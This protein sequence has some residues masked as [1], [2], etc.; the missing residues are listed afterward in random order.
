MLPGPILCA[1]CRSQ[2][3]AQTCP[4]CSSAVCERCEG[5]RATCTALGARV[6]RLGRDRRLR[7]VDPEGRVGLVTGLGGRFHEIFDL[8]SGKQIAAP[9]R[10]PVF[11]APL[12]PAVARGGRAIWPSRGGPL[13]DQTSG[14]HGVVVGSVYDDAARVIAPSRVTILR[15]LHLC[16]TGRHA[17]LLTGPDRVQVWD[18]ETGAQHEY[19]P[20][21]ASVLQASALD[22]AR[23]ILASTTYG[24][25]SLM[26]LEGARATPLGLLHLSR[27]NSPWIALS[28]TCVAVISDRGRSE[29]HVI[30]AFALDPDG[31]L[32]SQPIYEA[33]EVAM[34]EQGQR[35]LQRPLVAALSQDGRYLA[36]AMRNRDIAVHDLQRGRV[37]HLSGHAERVAMISFT[38]GAGSLVTSD[39]D[40]RVI[41]WPRREHEF[42]DLAP[43]QRR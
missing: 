29:G 6:L 15:A 31:A 20:F 24:R 18:L 9:P 23:L 1:H 16:P 22:S 41:F 17:W 28:E 2:T 30:R 34:N 39:Y 19:T 40:D 25:V 4:R 14:F 32:A 35:R 33:P 43:Y 42:L 11:K 5:D 38:T 21:A 26:R 27:A 8:L 36:A 13:P 7:R 37:Q 12:S 10:V 3:A